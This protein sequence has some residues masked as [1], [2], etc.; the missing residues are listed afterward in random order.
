MSPE[1]E[2]AIDRYARWLVR[3]L[4]ITFSHARLIAE[5]AMAPT[6]RRA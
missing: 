6:A 3:R 1:H 2:Y 4:S 5:I